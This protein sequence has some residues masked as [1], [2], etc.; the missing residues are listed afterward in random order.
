SFKYSNGSYF[1]LLN[2]KALLF[3][4]VAIEFTKLKYNMSLVVTS[5]SLLKYS[6]TEFVPANKSKK[7]FSFPLTFLSIIL[8]ISFSNVTFEPIYL[9]F[10]SSFILVVYII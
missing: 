9:I 10:T 6:A 1:N 7:D 3:S 2:S 4:I 8:L 5:Y